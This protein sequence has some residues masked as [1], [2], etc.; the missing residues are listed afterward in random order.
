MAKE[1]GGDRLGPVEEGNAG[2]RAHRAGEVEVHD[3]VAREVEP[4]RLVEQDQEL[5]A[6]GDR[7]LERVVERVRLVGRGDRLVGEV[8]ERRDPLVV[9][10]GSGRSHVEEVEPAGRDREEGRKERRPGAASALGS[11]PDEIEDHRDGEGHLAGVEVALDVGRVGELEGV[12]EPQAAQD[13]G[14]DERGER[15]ARAAVDCDGARDDEQ[16]EGLDGLVV[17]H[18]L[19]EKLPLG[20]L[21]IELLSKPN[22]AVKSPFI[23]GKR[24]VPLER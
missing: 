6:L 21:G 19:Q 4:V 10:G 23:R 17:E 24:K 11:A 3:A 13:H 5:L 12:Q 18:R 8:R 14:E 7:V 15:T 22:P 9:R 2:R 1:V 16:A 20:D